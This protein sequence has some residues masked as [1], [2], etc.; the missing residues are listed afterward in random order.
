MALYR[1]DTPTGDTVILASYVCLIAGHCADMGNPVLQF[2]QTGTGANTRLTWTVA[3]TV[4]AEQL[5]HFNSTLI[6]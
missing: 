2:G 5:P 6:G 4:P 1:L 3:S